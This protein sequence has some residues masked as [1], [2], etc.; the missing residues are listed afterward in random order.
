M[1][2]ILSLCKGSDRKPY[3]NGNAGT[4][5]PEPIGVGATF[6]ASLFHA[7]GDLTSTE[8]RGDQNGLGATYWAPN[9]NIFRDPRWGRGQ[10]TPGEDPTLSGSYATNFVQGMQGNDTTY[11]K[12]SACLK[13]FSAYSQE[14]GTVCAFEHNFAF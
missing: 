7:L 14:T 12:V 4:V 6:N 5:W 10:E 3:G 1:S 9:V 8:C 11:L 13:H 2:I